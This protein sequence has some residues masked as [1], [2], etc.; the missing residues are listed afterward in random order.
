MRML[1]ARV[2][3]WISTWNL[4]SRHHYH[5][6]LAGSAGVVDSVHTQAPWHH[7]HDSK[8]VRRDVAS[9]QVAVLVAV[10]PWAELHPMLVALREDTP[11]LQ[12]AFVGTGGEG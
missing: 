8:V 3:S 4:K 12:H 1:T 5:G 10:V 2:N 7:V 11:A 9:K 6:E